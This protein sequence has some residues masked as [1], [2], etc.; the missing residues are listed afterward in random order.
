MWLAGGAPHHLS[1]PELKGFNFEGGTVIQPEFTAL[2]AGLVL[3][4][5]AFIAEIVRSGIL[6]LHKGQSEAAMAIGLSRM[7]GYRL[8]RNFD[9]PYV[10]MSIT[11]FW[12]RWHISLTTWI[13]DYLYKPLGG[14]R[15]GRLVRHQGPAS[16]EPR[17][18]A[19]RPVRRRLLEEHVS[20][21]GDLHRG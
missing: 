7:L 16:S 12:R 21:L 19:Q 6:A 14:N 1:W 13:R 4:T 20:V 2:L 3:Y 9:F 11:E 5:S 15:G 17:D 10:S 18:S 8:P